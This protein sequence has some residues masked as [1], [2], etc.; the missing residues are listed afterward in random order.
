MVCPLS[1]IGQWRG[2]LESKT[3]NG[4]LS[5]SFYYGSTKNRCDAF[6]IIQS[7]RHVDLRDCYHLTHHDPCAETDIAL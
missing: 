1:L 5:V 7:G 4:A 3:R 6:G 2:E